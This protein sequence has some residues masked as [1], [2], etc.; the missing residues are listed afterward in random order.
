MM[1]SLRYAIYAC[2]LT[3]VTMSGT[4]YPARGEER[5]NADQA[6]GHCQPTAETK[7]ISPDDLYRLVEN[8][9]SIALEKDEFETTQEFEARVASQ[10]QTIPGFDFSIGDEVMLEISILS[11][12]EYDAD[13]RAMTIQNLGINYIGL[14][15]IRLS[16]GTY[17]GIAIA[18]RLRSESSYVGINAFGAQ[19]D[20]LLREF[21]LVTLA[22]PKR[23]I[24]VRGLRSNKEARQRTIE[25]YPPER[26]RALRDRGVIRI[27]GTVISPVAERAPTTGTTPTMRSPVERRNTFAAMTVIPSDVCLIDHEQ[28]ILDR[29][30]IELRNR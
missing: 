4:I 10:S 22:W 5:Q 25:N 7:S 3:G 1:K 19:T 9:P 21:D 18:N 14:M 16:S 11:R 30:E 27:I 24:R 13:R 12:L 8:P 26:A 2:A 23:T 20:I 17:H 6:V 28:Q 29:W 15:P